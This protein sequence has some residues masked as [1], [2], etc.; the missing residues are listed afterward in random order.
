MA[1][2]GSG[3]RLIGSKEL[4]ATL[5]QASPKA[6]RNVLTRTLTASARRNAQAIKDAARFVYGYSTGALKRSIKARKRRGTSTQVRASVYIDKREGAGGRHWHLVEFGARGGKMPAQPFITP[7]FLES[8]EEWSDYF[9][10]RFMQELAAE[11]QKT[12]SGAKRVRR[13]RD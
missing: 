12:T 1:Q 8:K 5:V 4:I 6:A 2:Y 13:V 9:R 10:R 11:I 7:A 3:M